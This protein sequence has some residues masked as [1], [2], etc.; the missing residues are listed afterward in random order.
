MRQMANA[1]LS[2]V[3]KYN[4]QGQVL[5]ESDS[6]AFLEELDNQD[7]VVQFVVSLGDVDRGIADAKAT[8][9]RGISLKYGIE[10]INSEVVDLIHKKGYGL[11]LWVINEPTDIIATWT[12][13]PDFIQT[14]NADFKP[15]LE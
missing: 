11:I 15:Y 8:K 14:D 9:S 4:M 10:E 1:I 7:I 6:L 5:V 3:V 12:A 13:Q 2:L